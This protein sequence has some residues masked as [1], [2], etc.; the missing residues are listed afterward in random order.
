MKNIKFYKDGD[1]VWA[2][3]F[4]DTLLQQML[5]I[6]EDKLTTKPEHL[7]SGDKITFLI[8]SYSE[9]TK[10]IDGGNKYNKNCLD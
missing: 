6:P 7:K 10:N 4:K 2:L 3:D 9:P 1:S 5:G 8:D